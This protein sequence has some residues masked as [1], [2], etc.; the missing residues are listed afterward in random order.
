MSMPG[1]GCN[2]NDGKLTSVRYFHSPTGLHDTALNLRTE[3]T[4]PLSPLRR[5]PLNPSALSA[6]HCLPNVNM[7]Y[8]G[9]PRTASILHT[10]THITISREY[11]KQI[12]SVSLFALWINGKLKCT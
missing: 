1:S 9:M 10:Q 8:Y 12:E 5:V 7:T 6:E 3:N 4:F 11:V 2:C